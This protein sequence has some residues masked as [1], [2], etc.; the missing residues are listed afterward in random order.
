[1]INKLLSE[2]DGEVETVSAEVFDLVSASYLQDHRHDLATSKVPLYLV[3]AKEAGRYKV[4]TVTLEQVDSLAPAQRNLEFALPRQ[5]HATPGPSNDSFLIRWNSLLELTPEQRIAELTRSRGDFEQKITTV[6]DPQQ[7]ARLIIDIVETTFLVN[8]ST[9]SLNGE[10]TRPEEQV[11]ISQ[12]MAIIDSVLQILEESELSTTLFQTLQTLSNG[13]TLGHIVR[14]FTLLSG[15]LVFYGQQHQKGLVQKVRLTF[16]SRYR[17]HYR[18]LLPGLS[19]SLLT[20]D[21]LVRLPSLTKG[22]LRTFALGALMHD[23]GKIMDLDYFET[24]V[25]YDPVKIRQHPILGSGLFL[26]TYGLKYEE[27]RFI[28]GDHHNYLFQPD[29][30][31]LT[32]WDRMRSGR[33][34]R[35]PVCCVGNTLEVFTSG[36]ALTFL[37]IEMTAIADIY[38]ALVDPSRQYKKPMPPPQAVVAMEEG[39]RNRLKLDPILFDVFMDFLR[40]RGQEVPPHLGFQY[41]YD[42]RKETI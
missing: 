7:R 34:V 39:F 17:A 4:S 1:M 16:A 41:Q 15:F 36:E 42:R 37:P 24:K 14:V 11:L 18:R 30:Y 35:E 25:E 38:D 6:S 33:P 40:E 27:A 2:L 9:M 23:I 8:R 20:S 3:L 31:G 29:G 22:Q 5:W 12:T 21:N 19:D 13:Q 26:R 10:S 32:R 28:V